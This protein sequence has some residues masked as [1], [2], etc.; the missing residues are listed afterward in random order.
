[1][2]L[3][4]VQAGGN[5]T[6]DIETKYLPSG[7]CIAEF[8]I[9][10]NR[11]WYNDKKEKQEEVTFIGCTAFGKLAENIAK[12]FSKGMPIY[13]S[14]RLKQD[15]WEDKETGKKQSKTKVI[16][17]EFQ[18]IGGSKTSAPDASDRQPKSAPRPPADPDLDVQ[19]DDV[20]F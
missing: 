13:V 9:A 2:N 4:I 5:L 10:V 17:E 3:N 6:K 19:A 12:Y 20:H 11:V 16:V 18:F 7:T 8:G 15:Q 1:M 14:G